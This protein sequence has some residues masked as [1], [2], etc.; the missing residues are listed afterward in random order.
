MNRTQASPSRAQQGSALPITSISMVIP[1]Y[2]DETTIAKLVQDTDCLLKELSTDYEIVLL[3]DGSKDNTLAILHDLAKKFSSV[4]VVNHEVNQGYGKTIKEL[5]YAGTKDL[6]MS[7]PGDYQ[8]AP[9]EL[10]TMAQGLRTHDFVIGHRVKRND[11]PRRLLQS[12]IYNLMLRIFY[13]IS[14]KDVNSIK[15]FRREILKKITL[16]SDTPFVDA[17]LCIRAHRA[18]FKVIEIP[19]DHLPRLSTGASGGKISVITDT[20]GDLIR[21]STRV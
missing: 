7:L 16:E 19:I 21:M 6:V 10:I 15:L 14:F 18:G 5:Y 12:A 11:P 3:N 8:F 20:F 17:E 1:A 2:N 4:R 13:G 9:K